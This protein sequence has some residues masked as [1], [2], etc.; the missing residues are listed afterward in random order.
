[1][2][3]LLERTI[4]HHRRQLVVVAY[5]HD[6]LQA[7]HAPVRLLQE[8]GDKCLHLQDLGRLLHDKVIILEVQA[9]QG[10]PRERRVRTRHGDDAGMGRDQIVPPIVAV[11]EK[12]EGMALL[13]LLEHV[14]KV[15]VATFS[16]FQVRLVGLRREE[17]L[18]G[19]AEE[20]PEGEE[21][22]NDGPLAGLQRRPRLR[23]L[24]V[25]LGI[26]P[27]RWP[28]PPSSRCL[29]RGRRAFCVGRRLL[30]C[31]LPG[32]RL[33]RLCCVVA[34]P[35]PLR[36]RRPGLVRQRP[37]DARAVLASSDEPLLELLPAVLHVV[38]EEM[39]GVLASV[40]GILAL[41]AESLGQAL[42]LGQQLQAPLEHVIHTPPLRKVL[43]RVKL[44]NAAPQPEEVALGD[45]KGDNLLKEVVKRLVRVCH[46]D[47]LLVR[48]VVKKKIH[49]LNC[50]VRLPCPRWPNDHCQ[51]RIDTRA[52]GLDLHGRE[53]YLVLSRLALL[54][55]THVRQ[56]VRGGNHALR[57]PAAS[58]RAP[59]PL[60]LQPEG[61]LEVLGD[62]DVLRLRERL[63]YVVLIKEGVA[64]VDGVEHRREL[65]IL[66][67][68]RVAV[69]EEEVMEPVGDD[70]ILG[71]HQAADCLEDGLEVVLLGLAPNNEV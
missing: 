20:L 63:Q 48:E 65:P 6:P 56:R 66:R 2:S 58:L 24:L 70:G 10:G 15:A 54:I 41:D 34:L 35:P 69:A 17:G 68:A 8:H 45:I 33:Q 60:K 14:L 50:R 3:I 52:D 49:N 9:D 37:G 61:A 57:G 18:R 7:A 46:Q 16:D 53:S 21:Q 39:L 59:G 62:V 30:L 29:C 25:L 40:G 36:A 1:M 26:N 67:C 51:P 23:E 42:H 11:P 19:I 64:K 47:D 27:M 4:L 22:R 43:Y 5:E 32:F 13:D 28:L 31:R 44:L 71:V 55:W 38:Q 12:L